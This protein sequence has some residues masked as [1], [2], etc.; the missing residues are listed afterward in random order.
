MMQEVI[1]QFLPGLH[2]RPITSEVCLYAM[3]PDGHFYLGQTPRSSKVFAAAFAGHGF[4]FAPVLG[5]VMADLMVDEPAEFDLELFSPN[6]F[7]SG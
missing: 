6:R 1:A 2:Q 5:E 7:D 4:K 3:T